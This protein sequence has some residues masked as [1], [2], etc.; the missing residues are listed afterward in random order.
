[1]NPR[2]HTTRCITNWLTFEEVPTSSTAKANAK[3]FKSS[4][5]PNK[6]LLLEIQKVGKVSE[7]QAPEKK[8]LCTKNN[9]YLQVERIP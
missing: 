9:I 1:M 7:W 4:H 3:D 5:V 8:T 2:V 6:G